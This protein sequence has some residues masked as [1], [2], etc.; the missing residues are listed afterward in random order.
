MSDTAEPETGRPAK[1]DLSNEIVEVLGSGRKRAWTLGEIVPE[2][3]GSRRTV[4]DRLDEL[5]GEGDKIQSEKI[6]NATAYWVPE[7][8]PGTAPVAKHLGVLAILAFGAAC[9]AVVTIA[10][11]L[12]MN[13]PYSAAAAVLGGLA[14]LAGVWYALHRGRRLPNVGVLP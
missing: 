5:E 3:D 6:G 13:A 14:V 2:V 1:D 7:D 8:E 11:L 4:K 12:I 10:I 9:L